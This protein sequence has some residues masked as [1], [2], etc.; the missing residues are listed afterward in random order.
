MKTRTCMKV[1]IAILA[2]LA[3]GAF[4]MAQTIPEVK[5]VIRSEVTVTSDGKATVLSSGDPQ[6]ATFTFVSS[7]MSFESKVMKGAPFTADT[8]TEFSQTLSNGQKIYRKS[9]A[10]LARDSE[11]RTRREQTIDAIGPY[12]TSDHAHQTIFINDPVAGASYSLQPESKTAIKTPII[13]GEANIAMH[14]ISPTEVPPAGAVTHATI[15]GAGTVSAEK[16]ILM[17]GVKTAGGAGAVYTTT[18]ISS[19]NLARTESLGTRTF[20]GV[21][22]EGTRSIETI[23]AGTIGN[24]TPIEIVSE[25]WYS[26]ELGM[27]IKTVRSDPMAG[28]NV[29]QL[30]NIRR[31]E[32]SPSLF[33]VPSDY[34]V[35]DGNTKVQMIKKEIK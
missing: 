25:K 29:Y 2:F 35:K 27:V 33:Q 22:A 4:V 5:Q 1:T 16:V 21:A 3:L 12:A 30:T 6:N 15:S 28:E 31:T 18:T 24:D 17:D 7:E 20:D 8:V 26:Q 23:P 10:T 11:G 14:F 19:P 13:S 34:T 32:P 9:T